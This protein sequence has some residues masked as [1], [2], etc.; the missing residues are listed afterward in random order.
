MLW[1]RVSRSGRLAT[2]YYRLCQVAYTLTTIL[3]PCRH[4]PQFPSASAFVVNVRTDA[5]D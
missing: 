3:L 4:G 1:A 5:E 2:F